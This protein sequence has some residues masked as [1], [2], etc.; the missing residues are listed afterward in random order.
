VGRVRRAGVGVLCLVALFVAAL[1]NATG[2]QAE[3]EGRDAAPA[4]VERVSVNA[5]DYVLYD[6]YAFI[7]NL[8]SN[9]CMGVAGGSPDNG[10]FSVQWECHQIIGSD[11]DMRIRPISTG[12]IW[13]K[14]EPQHAANR[15]MG[16]SAARP[17][18]GTS[19]IQ[20]SCA[21]GLEQQFAFRATS[22]GFEIIVRH[23]NQCI[24]VSAGHTG[25]GGRVIQWPCTGGLDQ[26]WRFI[27]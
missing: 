23:S 18:Q 1:L 26:R 25:N 14:I 17:T 24:G 11:Q 12:S 8:N 7:R 9:R 13:H 27:I 21:S 10:V 6:G 2:A 19:L 5:V 16:I 22:N 4:T 20:W 3:P 15:C